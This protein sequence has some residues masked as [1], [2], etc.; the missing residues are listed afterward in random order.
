MTRGHPGSKIV[1][2]F[3]SHVF[4][5]PIKGIFVTV[6]TLEINIMIPSPDRQKSDI[7]KLMPISNESFSP[8]MQYLKNVFL[9]DSLILSL[10][11]LRKMTVTSSD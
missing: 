8:F 6:V 9:A 1:N 2:I 11:K 7:T 5:A 4:N 10:K 3:P